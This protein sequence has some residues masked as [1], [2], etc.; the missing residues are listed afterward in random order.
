MN[1]YG[2]QFISAYGRAQAAVWLLAANLALHLISLFLNFYIVVLLPGTPGEDLIRLGETNWFEV[3]KGFNAILS[4]FVYV[5]AAVAFLMWVHRTN[6]NLRSFGMVRPEFTPGWAVGWFFIPFANLG[7]PY[8]I[9]KEIWVG[10]DPRLS[11]PG[12]EAWQLPGSSSLLGWWW[13]CWL[14]AGTVNYIVS[15]LALAAKSPDAFF[16]AAKAQIFGDALSMG[17]AV[18]AIMVVKGIDRRQDLWSRSLQENYL[19]PP[20]PVFDSQQ[21]ERQ[22][23]KDNLQKLSSSLPA[24][25]QFMHQRRDFIEQLAR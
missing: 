2:S 1:G 7:M 18:L 10:S 25:T 5:A 21:T 22:A 19:P 15:R 8:K 14:L 24:S 3:L 13:G 12:E 16:N 4:F 9:V 20:P 6:K 17:A 23:R 11:E